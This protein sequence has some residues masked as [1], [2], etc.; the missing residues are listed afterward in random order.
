MHNNKGK[1]VSEQV[2]ELA[3]IPSLL[4]EERES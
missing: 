4:F 1:G 3:Y 2:D